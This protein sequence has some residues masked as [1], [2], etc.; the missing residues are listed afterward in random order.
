MSLS[1]SDSSVQIKADHSGTPGNLPKGICTSTVIINGGTDGFTFPRI[2]RKWEQSWKR[3]AFDAVFILGGINEVG[4]LMDSGMD[5]TSHRGLLQRS[6][7]ALSALLS[8]LSA[9]G[10]PQIFVLEPFL[11]D[12]PQYLKSWMGT[13]EE[14]RGMIRQTVASVLPAFFSLCTDSG[15]HV[16]PDH[17][18]ADVSRIQTVQNSFC[19]IHLLPMQPLLDDAVQRSGIQEITKDGIHLAHEG[20]HVLAEMI[21]KSIWST[22]D[23]Q[24]S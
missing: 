2:L 7:V 23:I 24:Q 5:E 18:S 14:V 10:C 12:T 21:V 4:A 11:F 19:R 16:T 6:A 15:F 17:M 20:H 22:Y 9:S 8:G 1:T 3:T 13:L